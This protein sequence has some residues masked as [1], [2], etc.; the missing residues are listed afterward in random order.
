M[1]SIEMQDSGLFA[2]YTTSIGRPHFGNLLKFLLIVVMKISIPD[3]DLAP[4]H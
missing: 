1:V 2:K 3:L 4:K